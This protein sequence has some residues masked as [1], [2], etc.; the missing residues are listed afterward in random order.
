MNLLTQADAIPADDWRDQQGGRPNRAGQAGRWLRAGARLLLPARA[1]GLPPALRARP[2]PFPDWRGK[3]ISAVWI[4]RRVGEGRAT[5]SVGGIGDIVLPFLVSLVLGPARSVAAMFY[6]PL[7]AVP[8]WDIETIMLALISFV[9][10]GAL[11]WWTT[12][13]PGITTERRDALQIGAAG[14]A[15]LVLGYA[16]AFTHF[17]PNAVVG[18]GTSVHLG[19]TLGM[20]V[21]AA[22]VAWL[23]PG[24]VRPRLATAVLAGYL[25]LAVAYYVTIERDFMRSWPH[26]PA[27][28]EEVLPSYAIR[29]YMAIRREMIGARRGSCRRSSQRSGASSKTTSCLRPMA[30]SS[31]G[32][33]RRPIRRRSCR[34]RRT[35]TSSPA[36]PT[37]PF[38]WAASPSSWRPTAKARF[39]STWWTRTRSPCHPARDPACAE[40]PSESDRALLDHIASV[41]D[42]PVPLPPLPPRLG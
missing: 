14:A 32:R 20:S 33:P 4:K 28:P 22:S 7:K 1:D 30:A 38:T 34:S 19:A 23:L 39:S 13:R 11:L 24:V 16:L 18:R 10:I 5:G 15:M 36:R 21:L 37:P 8:T 6:G 26:H 2:R 40:I 27:R 9:G 31:I 35:S 42:L 41:V 17:P 12:Q 29:V 3:R 25:A